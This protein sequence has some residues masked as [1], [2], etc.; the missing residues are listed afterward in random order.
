MI[1]LNL[2]IYMRMYRAMCVCVCV[3]VCVCLC[4]CV[5]VYSTC[6]AWTAGIQTHNISQHGRPT[7]GVQYDRDTGISVR[8]DRDTGISKDSLQTGAPM[9]ECVLSL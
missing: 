5:C 4:V 8:Y 1:M 7:V 9:I 6:Q 2:Y 3:S